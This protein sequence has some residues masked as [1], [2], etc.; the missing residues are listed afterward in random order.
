MKKVRKPAPVARR[1]RVKNHTT[2]YE[3]DKHGIFCRRCREYN[4]G[5]PMTGKKSVSKRCSI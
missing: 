1:K 2:N 3:A 5:C 4:G